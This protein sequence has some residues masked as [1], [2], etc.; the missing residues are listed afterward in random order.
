MRTTIPAKV[1]GYLAAGSIVAAALAVTAAGAT[2]APNLPDW[3]GVW[4]ISQNGPMDPATFDR[5]G[6]PYQEGGAREHPPYNPEWEAKYVANVAK[7]V[8]DAF[9][10]PINT[11]GT[12]SGFP[13]LMN[14]PAPYA[15]EFVVRPEQTWVL[16][17][18]G[19]NIA[20]IYTDG[21]DHPAQA[22]SWP[23][24]SGDSVGHWEGDVLVFH[25]KNLR[26]DTIYDRTGAVHSDQMEVSTRMRKLQSGMIEVKM[27][28]EDPVA[29]TKPW[30]ITKTFKKL[31]GVQ[32]LYDYACS[33]NDRNPVVDGRNSII[34]QSSGQ[35]SLVQMQTGH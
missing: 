23:T 22:D 2:R 10:D 4:V 8:L 17:E 27:V 25:T 6:P 14:I 20:R 5:S 33:E 11:C 34:L 28:I 1:Y 32:R 24:Y 16:T 15:Y 12:P 31:Q 30:L 35:S 29:F 3:S 9:P 21:R 19:P 18:N 7:T 13:R 26:G